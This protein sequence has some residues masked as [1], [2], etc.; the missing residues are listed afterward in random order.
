[1][2]PPATCSFQKRTSRWFKLPQNN[3]SLLRTGPNASQ[4][5]KLEIKAPADHAG[6]SALLRQ[7]VTESA[8]QAT[9]PSKLESLLRTFLLAVE[10]AAVMDA[11]EDTHQ[12]PSTT[13]REKVLSLDGFT[14]LPT[15]VNPTLSPHAITTLLVNMNHVVLPSLPQLAKRTVF[16]DIPDLIL[17]TNG[18]LNLSIQFHPLLRKSKPKS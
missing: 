13:G 4:S 10:L 12:E 8:L 11:M 18:L 1:M 3:S 16:L 9:K 6:L 5:N 14:T 15:G 2:K 17:L 7:S